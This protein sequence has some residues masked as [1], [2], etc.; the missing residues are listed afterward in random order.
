M[1]LLSLPRWIWQPLSRNDVIY[2]N[3]DD[4]ESIADPAASSDLP[5]LIDSSKNTA[6]TTEQHHFDVMLLDAFHCPITVTTGGR[7]G[8]TASVDCILATCSGGR[9]HCPTASPTNGN[10][11]VEQNNNPEVECGG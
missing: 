7:E 8:P 4:D 3:P 5:N 9:S 10:S 1:E 2:S 6:F 11:T